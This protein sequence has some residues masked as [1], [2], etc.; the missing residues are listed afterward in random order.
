MIGLTTDPIVVWVGLTYPRVACFGGIVK[1]RRGAVAATANRMRR[2]ATIG[3]I[4]LRPLR[5]KDN[6]V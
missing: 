2:T 3:K 1:S 6:C 5:L 4:L